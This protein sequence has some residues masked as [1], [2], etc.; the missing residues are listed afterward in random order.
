MNQEQR[1]EIQDGVRH[2][3]AAFLCGYESIDAQIGA[4]PVFSVPLRN[5]RSPHKDRID[6]VGING[7]RWERVLRGTRAGIILPPIEVLPGSKGKTLEE[8]SVPQDEFDLF[9]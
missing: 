6:T 4:G 1:Y 5:L 8:V 3:K 9:R 2:A 7:L